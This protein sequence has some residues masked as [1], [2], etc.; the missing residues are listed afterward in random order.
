MICFLACKGRE[1]S[2]QRNDKYSE[3]LSRKRKK[4]HLGAHSNGDKFNKNQNLQNWL[5]LAT[6][7]QDND[8]SHI[9]HQN[10][11]GN[12]YRFYLRQ[13]LTIILSR[14]NFL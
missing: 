8:T 11:P 3:Y 9:L 5:N 2:Y 14:L 13:T 4:R 7:M 1:N 12:V 10:N 6:E